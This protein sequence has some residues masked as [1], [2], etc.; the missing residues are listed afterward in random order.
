M[1]TQQ[2]PNAGYGGFSPEEL[3][4]IVRR[5]HRQRTQ[6]LREFFVWLFTRS[7]TTADSPEQPAGVRAVACG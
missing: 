6:A 1:T 2:H 3:Q 4:L 5:A 7:K